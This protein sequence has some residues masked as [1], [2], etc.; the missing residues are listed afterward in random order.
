MSWQRMPLLAL[1]VLAGAGLWLVGAA[2][3]AASEMPRMV[4]GLLLG[5]AVLG[6]VRLAQP[7][8]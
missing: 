2:P 6:L 3:A 5:G 4:G 1:L 7:T 8:A